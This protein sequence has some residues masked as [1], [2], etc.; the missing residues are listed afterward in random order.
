MRIKRPHIIVTAILL[1]LPLLAG[2]GGHSEQPPARTGE[3]MPSASHLTVAMSSLNISGT[4]SQAYVYVYVADRNGEVTDLTGTHVT[5]YT[6]T[7]A[8]E[9]YT[10]VVGIDGATYTY[11]RAQNAQ[12]RDVEPVAWENALCNRIESTYGINVYDAGTGTCT[13]GHPRDGWATLVV[14]M[15]GEEQFDDL[16]G[17]GVYDSGEPFSDTP[18]VF[19]DFN[20]NGTYDDGTGADPAEFYVDADGDGSFDATDGTWNASKTI[21]SSVTF[22][23][24]G[25]PYYVLPSPSTFAIA[26]GGSQTFTVLVSDYNFNYLVADTQVTVTLSGAGELAGETSY[27]FPS[28]FYQGPKEI[29]FTLSD[30]TAGDSDPAAVAVI[31]V[32]VSGP[33]GSNTAVITGTVD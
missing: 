18:E 6:E 13:A 12:P 23:I 8:I 4:D 33:S 14:A 28:G 9:P 31:T 1:L 11:F 3:A 19:V 10:S 2:C 22:M 5:Y 20:D 21:F 16:N 29:T 27:T 30:D 7:G 25:T 17:N 26:D 32:S 24:T 15:T